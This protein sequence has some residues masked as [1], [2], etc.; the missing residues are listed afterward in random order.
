M[1]V[2]TLIQGRTV[3]P[4]PP[5]VPRL[6][7]LTALL[8]GPAV[9]DDLFIDNQDLPQV[10]TATRLKQSPAAVPGSMTVL[11]SDLIR[12]SGARDIP[13]L[14]RLV[15]GM[16]IGY[17]AGNQPTVNY[18][19]SNVS[20]ARRMQVL[21]DGRSVYRAGLATVD[22]SDIPVA[23]EDIERIEVFRGPN[24]VSYGANALM[25]VV[26]ILTRNPAD[27]HG[28]RLKMTRG[29][30]GINDFYASQGLGWDG[31]DLRLSLSGQ[32]DD[33]FDQDQY[34]RDY[35]DSRR[36]NRIN[37]NVSQMLAPNQ[38]L[39]WQLAAKEGSNQRPYTYKPVF[40]FVTRA[41]DSADVNAKDYAGALRWSIDIN[42]EHSLYV[43][44]S[45]Q[46]FDRQ[47]VWRACDAALSFSQELTRLWQLDS[48]Y[49]EQVA[50]NITNPPG[51]SNPALQALRDQVKQQWDSQ[52]GSQVVCGD[53]DQSTRETRYDLEIQ[54]TLSLTDNLR[55]LSGANFRYDKADSQTYF[56]GTLDDQT[57]RLFGQLEWRADEHWILQGGAMFE[58]SRLSGSSLT[59]RVAVNY[60]ITPRHGLR[61]VYSEAVRS[62]DM[63]ENNVNWSYTVN[64][65]TPYQPW[66]GN[67]E[68]FV[69][70]RGPGDLDQER[71]RSRE[72]G[73]N[74]NFSD[75]DLSMD[76]KLFYDE[77][78]GMISEPL[79]NNQYIASN[80]NKAS[81]RGTEAQV[82]WRPSRR[83]RLRL[84]YAYVDAWAS[85]R[86]DSQN[87]ARN[88]GSA[89]WMRDWGAGWSSALFYYGDA[90]LNDYRFERIDLRVAKRL[91]IQ[92]TTLE[93]AALWQQR[94][95]DEPITLPQNRYDSRHRLS[96]SAELEF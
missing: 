76:V 45:A 95:D 62:P 38:T 18:H 15:P 94:L 13:E 81:F 3:F 60:L 21:I 44:G 61:A 22:W 72:L 59:P 39:E 11:D 17:G 70:T 14:L 68:Y 66:M 64:N 65:L 50:R 28:T 73:Y 20:E 40:P 23:L 93:L 16:M 10:L 25:A 51:N 56:N 12:A 52:G 58:D 29:E 83:D 32:Q 42:P 1:P 48:N 4:G 80:A 96:V 85:N 5:P 37:L 74:G 53:V 88:S 78:T 54:D 79:R 36:L 69:K 90:N 8:G 27:S 55:L 43:Q 26:N 46:H 92:G 2:S 30:D 41:G 91:R 84:S 49:A 75:I 33:G 7:L 89:G 57:W 35:R 63:F 77:I 86:N 82:D 71:M 34:G 47:Q 24:T 67:G 19:G 6:L 9:A 87:S 31:G